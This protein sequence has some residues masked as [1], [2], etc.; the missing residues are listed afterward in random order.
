MAGTVLITGSAGTVGRDLRAGLRG[1][2]GLLRLLDRAPQEPALDAAEEIVTADIGDED[3]LVAAM[4]GVDAVVHL[5]G[6]PVDA[7]FDAIATANL[8]GTQRVFDAARR[9]G[10]GRVVFASSHHAGGFYPRTHVQRVTDLPRPD[11][12]YG[13]SK[14]FGEAVARLYHDKH[15]IEAACLRIQSWTDRPTVHRHLGSWLSPRDG[16]ELVHRC[17]EVERLGFAIVFGVSANTRAW[18]RNE[19]LGWLGWEPQ[20]DAER[21]AAELEPP[22]SP[23]AADLLDG[24]EYVERDYDPEF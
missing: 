12:H 19:D 22:A 3:A 21:F 16:V 24:A 8:I 13:V 20:D 2:H 10:V 11:S 9:A 5:A 7:P 4:E 15:G 18:V 6:I 14:L 23:T 1:R 17:L